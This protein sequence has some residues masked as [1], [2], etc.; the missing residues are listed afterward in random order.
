MSL[1]EDQVNFYV[2]ITDN[3]LNSFIKDEHVKLAKPNDGFAFKMNVFS[4]Q[5]ILPEPYSRCK[6][7]PY[8]QKN[9][10][11]ECIHK[12]I[13]DKYNCIL[14]YI[15]FKM[16]GVKTCTNDY[17]KAKSS[18]IENE[19]FDV[20]STDCPPDC[21]L[22]KLSFDYLDSKS[23]FEDTV[24]IK[25]IK[26]YNESMLMFN[27][28]DFSYLNITQDPKIDSWTFINNIGGGLGL[29]MGIALPNFVE[30]F[31]FITNILII[32]FFE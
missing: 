30:F 11:E 2:Y 25:D 12:K 18:Y 19:Y 26:F 9:C 1:R 28:A 14:P 6:Q 16:K 32:T 27:I 23:P 10:I 5:T 31:Q 3:S 20:C 15:L 8:N 4:V 29:F 7:K 17:Y 13:Y 22:T 24:D 21:S